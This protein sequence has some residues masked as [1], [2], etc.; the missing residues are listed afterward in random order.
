LT[1]L[2]AALLLE[3]ASRV[4]IV[5][6]FLVPDAGKAETDGPP[7]SVVL[8]RALALLAKACLIATDP[9]CLDVLQA[10]AESVGGP[11]VLG[12]ST[13]E[14]ILEACPDCLV[15]VE[16]LGHAR[17]GCYYNMRGTDITAWTSPL[18]R[19]AGLARKAGIGVIA[20]GDGGNEA[21]MGSLGENLERL[22]T[23]GFR[24]CL[25]CVESD[26]CVPVDVSNWGCYALT[27][28]LSGFSRKWLGHSEEEESAMLESMALQG[29]VDGA[30]RENTR[31]VDGF[32]EN[33]N[34]KLVEA[35]R[36][37]FDSFL[38]TASS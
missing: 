2:E 15:F 32:S 4:V 16:R 11:P 22:V 14:E 23:P 29:A 24:S 26:I 35:V 8:G 18:D 33:E 30:T 6:G 1:L 7:G 10:C 36:E 9:H 13:A 25:C 5:T 27:A 38:E 19:A 34:R 31:T 17:D 28:L 12:V 37:E 3:K 20:I 21:G